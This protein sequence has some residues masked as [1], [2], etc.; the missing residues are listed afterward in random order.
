MVDKLSKYAH[1]V[2]VAHPF[3]TITIAQGYFDNIFKL[4]G[5]PRTIVSD[6]DVVFLSHFLRSLFSLHGTEI[7]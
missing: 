3:S 6:R 1:F 4:H 2:A 5:W 7:G